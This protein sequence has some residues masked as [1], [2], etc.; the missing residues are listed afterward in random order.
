MAFNV[1]LLSTA[2]W[3]AL[4]LLKEKMVILTKGNTGLKDSQSI[5]SFVKDATSLTV[6]DSE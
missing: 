5:A 3:Y 1:I 4:L 6:S 2:T